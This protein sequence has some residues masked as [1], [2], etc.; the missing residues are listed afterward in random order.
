MSPPALPPDV[1]RIIFEVS[2]R[3]RPRHIPQL[4]LVARR[5]K[6]WIEP[7]LYH[8]LIVESERTSLSMGSHAR[9]LGLPIC[10][11]EIFLTIARDAGGRS[12]MLQHVR[13]IYLKTED[14]E[15]VALILRV[16][17]GITNLFAAKPLS[18][19]AAG[20]AA[21]L[22]LQHLY[23]LH[24]AIQGAPPHAVWSHLT[25]LYLYGG[26]GPSPDS[27]PDS[28]VAFA[29]AERIISLPKLTHLAVS[30]RSVISAVIPP[31]ER[32]LAQCNDLR[33]LAVVGGV[34]TSGTGTPVQDPR[35]AIL[36]Q[37]EFTR[38]WME[39]V[40]RGV[41][42]WTF[43]ERRVARQIAVVAAKQAQSAA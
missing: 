42:F 14:P 28:A 22:P 29:V 1:E 39:G 8:T 35:F 25:H 23:A 9:T 18:E 38:D 5:V 16:C 13:N 21:E 41:D 11:I 27:D 20:A 6:Q 36:P 17:K 31:C 37:H 3:S 34:R 12:S 26:F 7:L 15:H 40:V 33:V 4:I 19:P 24:G 30:P 2:A 32:I 10:N 43:A